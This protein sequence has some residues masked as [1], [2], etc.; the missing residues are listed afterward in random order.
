MIQRQFIQ[1]EKYD[2][3]I[4]LIPIF[5]LQGTPLP[6][7]AAEN[8]TYSDMIRVNYASLRHHYI[9]IYMS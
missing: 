3:P 7:H 9:M 5:I 2:L 6:H 8:S 4:E 1:Y